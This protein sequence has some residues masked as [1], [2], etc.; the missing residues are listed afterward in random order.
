M[1]GRISH[2]QTLDPGF[3]TVPLV[4]I[5]QTSQRSFNN[6]L[7]ERF[8]ERNVD[9]RLQVQLEKD[10]GRSARQSWVGKGSLWPLFHVNLAA[11][12]TRKTLMWG[13]TNHFS[14]R[15]KH[16]SIVFTRGPSSVHIHH[17]DCAT[18][19]F[20]CCC[21][22]WVDTLRPTLQTTQNRSFPRRSSQPIS[23]LTTEKINLT[24]Q[25]KQYKNK[26]ALIKTDRKHIQKANLKANVIQL[27]TVRTTINV[28]ISL[29][30]I[31]VHSTAQN[32]S[33]NLP[34]YPSCNHH[35]SDVVYWS[36]GGIAVVSC[37]NLELWPSPSNLT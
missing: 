23:W 2:K 8:K 15:S 12:R 7:E 36:V 17:V 10:G 24:Q 18:H 5:T 37:C 25:S 30:T 26:T 11:L 31:I 29:C 22:Y 32:S 16:I 20:G 35:S 1:L 33:D 34:A 13:R 21:C 3:F 27:L 9:G 28:C 19:G 4:A 14:T 6:C